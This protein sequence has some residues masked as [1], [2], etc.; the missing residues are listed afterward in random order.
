MPTWA[1]TLA[2]NAL[3]PRSVI[4]APITTAPSWG[5]IFWNLTGRGVFVRIFRKKAKK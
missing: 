4:L 2:P 1:R 3:A 5:S